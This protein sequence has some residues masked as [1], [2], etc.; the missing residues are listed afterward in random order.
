MKMIPTESCREQL[1]Y[2]WGY[3]F[4]EDPPLSVE[5]VWELIKNSPIGKNVVLVGDVVSVNFFEKG[6][7]DIFVIDLKTRR[8]TFPRRVNAQGA[9]LS[10]KN[11]P[12]TITK[13]C[14]EALKMSFELL[15]KNRKPILL[16]VDGEEDLLSLIAL[17]LCPI[18]NSWIIYGHFK[19]FICVIPCTAYFK[20]IA[21]DLLATCFEKH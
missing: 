6:L 12:G 1:S 19:G 8:G 3:L 4:Y 2:S 17:Y 9:V 11:P 20:K 14:F 21:G 7:G 13:D 10:C 16:Q 18:N 15:A 5:K